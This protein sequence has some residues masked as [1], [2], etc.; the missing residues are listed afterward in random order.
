MSTTPTRREALVDVVLTVLLLPASAASAV[1]VVDLL[2]GGRPSLTVTVF[3]QAL[4]TLAGV[5]ALLDWRNRRWSGIG[6]HRP[7]M[8]DLGRALLILVAG[9]GVNAALVLAVALVSPQSVYAHL[10]ELQSVAGEL[11]AGTPFAGVLALLLLVGIYEEV[12]ARG[13]LLTRARELFGGIWVPVLFSSVLFGLGHFYQGPFGVVQTAIFGA[14]L[15]LFTI[16]WGTLWPAI[17]A[18]AAINML[19]VV[20]L[21]KLTLPS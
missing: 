2:M 17:M 10:G 1:V 6:M 3:V 13:L 12:L 9:I 11:T 5:N 7:R 16:R 20:Q 4:L 21:D 8:A 19:S 15:A 14:V 18:H